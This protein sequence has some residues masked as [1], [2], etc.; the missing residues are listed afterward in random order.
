MASHL[1]SSTTTISARVIMIAMYAK[2]TEAYIVVAIIV[3]GPA[4]GLA[5]VVALLTD[6]LQLHKGNIEQM[7]R[8]SA[9]SRSGSVLH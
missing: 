9:C 5:E 1:S 6:D 2:H 3:V 4:K 7:T 8:V